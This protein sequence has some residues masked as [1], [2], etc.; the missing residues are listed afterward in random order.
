MKFDYKNWNLET[1]GSV[2]LNDFVF[3]A[4]LRKDIIAKVVNWQRAK[5]RSGNHSTK[6]LK[7]VSGTTRKPWGQKET[8]RARQGSLRAPQFRKGGVVFGPHPRDY[9][10]KLNKK[11][12]VLGNISSLTYKL[13]EGLFSVFENYDVPF[14]KTA[15]FAKWIAKA[16]L[17]SVLFVVPDAFDLSVFNCIHNVPYCD[18]IPVRG[19]NVLDIVKHKNIFCDLNALS[20]IEERFTGFSKIAGANEMA[21]LLNKAEDAVNKIVEEL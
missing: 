17:K 2:E 1:V 5:A 15:E 3:D 20:E 14:V 8:G 9:S 12:K 13:K 11:V 7:D 18:V 10:Y 16:E 19:L 21:Q 4:P 6:T